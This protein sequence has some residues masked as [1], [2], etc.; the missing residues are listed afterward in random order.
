M[1]SAEINNSITQLIAQNITKESVS[2]SFQTFNDV[3][4]NR[5]TIDAVFNGFVELE[6]ALN[7][8]QVS[9]I[10]MVAS[11][12]VSDV[13]NVI[14]VNKIIEDFE[15]D[16]K[17]FNEMKGSSSTIWIIILVGIILLC[18]VGGVMYYYYGNKEVPETLDDY[19]GEVIQEK[20]IMM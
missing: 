16:I 17:V 12:L 10:D 5:L 2:K 20:K 11:S 6:D 13:S 15:N 1:N 18:I 14:D 8:K 9:S 3:I 4:N 19:Q 7:I